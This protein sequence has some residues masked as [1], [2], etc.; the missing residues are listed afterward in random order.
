MESTNNIIS[1]FS[2]V[3][4]NIMEME[5]ESSIVFNDTETVDIIID[6]DTVKNNKTKKTSRKPPQP[7]PSVEDIKNI[8]SPYHFLSQFCETTGSSIEQ[9]V[10][11]YENMKKVENMF[12]PLTKEDLTKKN[13][14]NLKTIFVEKN[15]CLY[16]L[17]PPTYPKKQS[18][19]R[20]KEDRIDTILQFQET[21]TFHQY[22]FTN[23]YKEDEEL[24]K[25]ILLPPTVN[26]S[27]INSQKR[28]IY[29]EPLVFDEDN[30]ELLKDTDMIAE[31]VTVSP[32]DDKTIESFDQ[33]KI[34]E[35]LKIQINKY[36][37]QFNNVCIG[38]KKTMYEY[39]EREWVLVHTSETVLRIYN[40]YIV[41]K[42][43][44]NSILQKTL[45]HPECVEFINEHL[46]ELFTTEIKASTDKKTTKL[47]PPKKST[48][49]VKKQT[50]KKEKKTLSKKSKKQQKDLS[51]PLQ[52]FENNENSGEEG[53]DEGM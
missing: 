17:S 33:E 7:K 37:Q 43:E 51:F 4:G 46:L 24:K 15:D 5:T 1:S 52:T 26:M 16:T 32:T 44:E 3:S 21:D 2:S 28:T 12:T 30:V 36:I 27:I 34:K 47:L 50:D 23:L 49:P 31:M 11:L 29:G 48:Q 9:V 14:S 10:E 42:T 6:T 45:E 19:P 13:T 53:D 20:K 22:E 25:N 8:V 41:T 40:S 35:F 39:V 38:N 18:L